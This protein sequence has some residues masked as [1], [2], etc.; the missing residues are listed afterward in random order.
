MK[1]SGGIEIWD[2]MAHE[3]F[4]NKT[5]SSLNN[6]VIAQYGIPDL[7]YVTLFFEHLALC[8]TVMCDF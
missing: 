4:Q 7:P 3:Y 2:R 6:D 8:N 1:I 5:L